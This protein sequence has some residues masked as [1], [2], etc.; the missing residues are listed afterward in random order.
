MQIVPNAQK[1][2]GLGNFPTADK[3]GSGGKYLQNLNQNNG[4]I[5]QFF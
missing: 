3:Q 4:S 5:L 1:L 2:E